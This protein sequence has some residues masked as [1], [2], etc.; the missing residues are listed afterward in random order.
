MAIIT[1]Q[2]ALYQS[3]RLVAV[4]KNATANLSAGFSVGNRNRPIQPVGS[5]QVFPDVLTEKLIRERSRLQVNSSLALVD[6]R[7]KTI[8]GGNNVITTQ[9]VNN[10]NNWKSTAALNCKFPTYFRIDL[11]AIGLPEGTDVVVDIEEGFA[12]EADYPGSPQAPLPRQ[13][14]FVSFRTPRTGHVDAS[15]DFTMPNVA[16]TNFR[17][18]SAAFTS[19]FSPV[20]IG[21][22]NRFGVSDLQSAFQQI[23]IVGFR[24]FYASQM[25]AEFGGFFTAGGVARIATGSVIRSF[26][27]DIVSTSNMV[28]EGEDVKFAD[29]DLTSV[30]TIVPDVDAFKGV[31]IVN[32]EADV[33]LISSSTVSYNSNLGNLIAQSSLTIRPNRLGK[34]NLT[35]T[36]SMSINTD[37]LSEAIFTI[38]VPS[39]TTAERTFGFDF[40]GDTDLI[41]DWGNG[42]TTTVNQEFLSFS[43]RTQVYNAGTYTVRLTK[44]PVLDNA[45]GGKQAQ[46]YRIRSTAAAQNMVREVISFGELGT[47]SLEN[48]FNNCNNIIPTSWPDRLPVTITNI[49]RLLPRNAN[50]VAISN[51]NTGN[52]TN[53]SSLFANNRSFNYSLNNWNMSK[54]TTLFSMF[55]SSV[56]NQPLDNWDVSKVTDFRFMFA[57]TTNLLDV[58]EFNQ[59]INNWQLNTTPGVNITLQGMFASA[60]AFNQ[61]LNSWNTSR[62][63]NMDS[64]FAGTLVFN[65]PLNS[66]N[67]SNVNNMTDMFFNAASFDQNIS[68]W[69][70][71][72]IPTK[73]FRFDTGTLSTWIEAEKPVWGTCP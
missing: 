34:A 7:L 5:D 22:L 28:T 58:T 68:N 18:F 26:E 41:I 51:W 62:V 56:F 67:T 36:S 55:S 38:L 72:L 35:A 29:A 57:S 61:P 12:I 39:G 54:A 1:S 42:Q 8:G 19:A 64:L 71:P 3:F 4:D 25:Q 17:P 70:V 65:Q 45:R 21:Q 30:L 59:N 44:P 53:F 11:E 16:Y 52:V 50:S 2:A 27:T 24:K 69:C 14:N 13:L 63:N 20:L 73:P 49:A 31:G 66:W 47:L 48:A 46:Q 9:G 60:W 40:L 32:L 23:T 6:E 43:T 15:S 10:T 33:N 37:I